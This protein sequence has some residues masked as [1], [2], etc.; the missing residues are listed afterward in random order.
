MSEVWRGLALCRT[1]SNLPWIAEPAERSD[2]A[3]GA[4]LAVC[5]SCPVFSDCAGYAE[6]H[7]INSGFWAGLDWSVQDQERADL[8][9][10]PQA[11][12]AA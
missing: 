5:L 11:G 1:F 6:R 3:V 9:G 7:G 10:G 12:E 8:P 2:A 4:M